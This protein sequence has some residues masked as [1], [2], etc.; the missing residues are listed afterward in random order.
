VIATDTFANPAQQ[1]R[2]S[3]AYTLEGVST[4]G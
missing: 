3:A 4:K 2:D 1:Y